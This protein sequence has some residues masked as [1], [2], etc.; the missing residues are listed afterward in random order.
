MKERRDKYRISLENYHRVSDANTGS[1]IFD[2]TQ[3]R[4]NHLGKIADK[5][6]LNGEERAIILSVLA[7]CDVAKCGDKEDREKWQRDGINLKIHIVLVINGQIDF[8]NES[9]ELYN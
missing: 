9:G 5:Y 6:S 4:I 3:E 1:L 7:W 2:L 8:P